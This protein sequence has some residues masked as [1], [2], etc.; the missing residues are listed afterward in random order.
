MIGEGLMHK[1]GGNMFQRINVDY[2]IPR[3]ASTALVMSRHGKTLVFQSPVEGQAPPG[4][5]K[6]PYE[7]S[8]PSTPGRCGSASS[9]RRPST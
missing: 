9:S 7:V 4:I 6:P 2:A 5:K 1:L 8:R 3:H